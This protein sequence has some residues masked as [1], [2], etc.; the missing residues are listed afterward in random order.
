MNVC[1]VVKKRMWL[2][3]IELVIFG[4]F[5]DVCWGRGS[6]IFMILVVLMLCLSFESCM[7]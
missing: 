4:L 5:F 2:I 6:G 7:L 1:D 3:G